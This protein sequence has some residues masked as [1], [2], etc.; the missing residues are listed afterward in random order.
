MVLADP[1]YFQG[2]FNLA[3]ALHGANDLA[4]A[5]VTYE[6]ALVIDPLSLTARYNFALALDKQKFPLDSA[7]ELEELL[8]THPAYVP[9]HLQAGN[10]Y[11]QQLK[12][13]D[14]ARDHYRRVLQLEPGHA[15]ATNIRR[16]RA[17]LAPK[18]YP[19]GPRLQP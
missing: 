13:A 7:N 15:E 16:W 11:A 2:Q 10:L 8:V 3:L 6:T 18:Q 19:Q 12:Q 5:L 1:S 14:R 17:A 4:N 9:A